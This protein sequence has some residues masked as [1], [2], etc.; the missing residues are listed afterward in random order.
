[1]ADASAQPSIETMNLA[2]MSAVL[3]IQSRT[4]PPSLIE[5]EAV[6]LN[7]LALP[8]SYCLSARIAGEAV[9]YLLAYGWR[10]GSP[11]PIGAIV[12]GNDPGEVLFIHD[13]A[14]SETGRGL[15]IG[16]LLVDHALAAAARDKLHEAQLVA[17]EGAHEYWHRLGFL[18]PPVS[19]ELKTKLSS[20]GAR[21]RWMTRSIPTEHPVPR[22]DGEASSSTRS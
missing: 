21:A 14:V 18:E 8:C 7:R 19:G 10:D 12:E 17:V 20:Y 5:D 11:P 4:Y 15:G 16:K 9:G 3:A 2:D 13:L 22:G 1:M 6:F